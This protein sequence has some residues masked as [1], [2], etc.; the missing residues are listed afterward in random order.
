[1]SYCL[2][3]NCRYPKDHSTA[4]HKCGTC[5]T[6]GHGR[7]ECK[8]S[9]KINY[10]KSLPTYNISLPVEI[11][12]TIPSCTHRSSH[13]NTSHSCGLCND[14]HSINTCV[15][16]K[17]V[18][19]TVKHGKTASIN[20]KCPLCSTLND[21]LLNQKKTYGIS[22]N[23]CVCC[24]SN[25]VEVYLPKCGH[26]C[27]CFDCALTM[28]QNSVKDSNILDESGLKQFMDV[29]NLKTQLASFDNK[30]YTVVQL[31]MGNCCYVKRD[32]INDSIKGYFM[33]SD[34]WGQYNGSDDRPSLDK[35]VYG[36]TETKLV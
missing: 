6:Y 15:L 22:E 9:V 12:C 30:I 32:N 10:L 17:N 36:Y 28:D 25:S 33:H 11:Q 24:Q 27:L 31:G 13:T 35:F 4:A 8:N 7:C 19:S 14:N 21:V 26:V 34:N 5:K 2:V 20:I 29:N 18:K 16:A 3:K 1:M 23:I